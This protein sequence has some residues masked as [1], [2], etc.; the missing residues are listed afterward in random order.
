LLASMALGIHPSFE[1]AVSEM[2]GEERRIAP[3]PELVQAYSG[4]FAHYR[5]FRSLLMQTNEQTNSPEG[6][7]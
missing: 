4:Q 3:E 6:E 1:A 2:T 5:Q 7:E